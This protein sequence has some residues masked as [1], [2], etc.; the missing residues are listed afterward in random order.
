MMKKAFAMLLCMMLPLS[1][2]AQWDTEYKT[3]EKSIR[4]VTFPAG[5]HFGIEVAV[6]GEQQ[7][8]AFLHH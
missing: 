8:G 6:K 5:E 7:R 3:L 2:W 1:I 4:Q